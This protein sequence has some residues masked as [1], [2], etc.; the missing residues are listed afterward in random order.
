MLKYKLNLTEH[1]NTVVMKS[2]RFNNRYIGYCNK[3]QEMQVQETAFVDMI[4]EE[5]NI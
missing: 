1:Q 5:I 2:G 4:E 3:C